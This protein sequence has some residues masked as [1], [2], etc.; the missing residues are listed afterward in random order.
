MVLTRV[1]LQMSSG[2]EA[3]D[4][5]DFLQTHCTVLHSKELPDPKCQYRQD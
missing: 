2:V 5:A 1:V 3:R 4:A